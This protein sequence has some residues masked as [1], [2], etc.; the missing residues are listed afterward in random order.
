MSDLL[1]EPFEYDGI[2]FPAIV[3]PNGDVGLPLRRLTI[4]IGLDPD[5]QRERV[6]RAVWSK[7][8]TAKMDVRLPG[9]DR[10]RRHFVI[11]H[12]IVPM[13]VAGIGTTQ[14]KDDDARSR[15]ERW[16]I[17]FAD[18]LYNYVFHGGA[19][20]PRA[21]V[22][23]LD[24]ID[25][26]IRRAKDQAEFLAILRQGGVV[27]AGYLDACGRRLAGRVLGETPEFDPTT[28]PL[29]VSIFLESKNLTSTEIKSIASS[30]GKALKKLYISL[31]D[32]APPQIED[33][34]GRHMV[35]VAQYQERHRP[36]FD[37][38]YNSLVLSS[39]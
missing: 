35:P 28:K 14:M 8:R 2:Q 19:I 34:V 12:R 15:I 21:T 39:A 18:A 11:S 4:P 30:F 26:K 1:P 5:A 9:D 16:Q 22:E 3:M 24:E 17:E 37:Q 7:G 36:L 27:D 6:E 33:M 13:W 25:R 32:E 20:N 10:A 29:T 31:F 38:V 23:Q